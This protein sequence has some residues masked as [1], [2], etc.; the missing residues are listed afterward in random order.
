MSTIIDS[1]V[2]L[3]LDS[4]LSIGPKGVTMSTIIDSYVSLTDVSNAYNQDIDT[5]YMCLCVCLCVCS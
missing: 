4:I 2:S 1:Y 5:S 3:I